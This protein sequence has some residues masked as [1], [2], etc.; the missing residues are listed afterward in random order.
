MTPVREL[1][2]RVLAGIP[3]AIARAITWA[4]TADPRFPELLSHL[5]PRTGR[6]RVIG[7]TGA[8]GAGKSTLTAALAKASRA[9]GRRIG[10]IAVDP[11][12]PFT[13]GAILGD[14]IRMQ[15]LYTD[16]GVMIRSMATRGHLGGLSRAT[17]DAVDVLDAA[18]FDDVLV[19]TVGVGQ[20]EV[21][22][23]RLAET[24]VVLLTPGMGDDIQAIK[25]GLMEVADVFVVNKADR[26][27]ADRTVQEVL[28]ML[29]M[30][31][32]GAWIPPVLKT[33]A[34]TGEGVPRLRAELEK[35][36]E[37]LSGPSGSSRRRERTVRR[38]ESIVQEKLLAELHGLSGS[39]ASIA[40]WAGRIEARS[41]DPFRAAGALL[42][43]LR[44]NG[45]PAAAKAGVRKISH[46]GLAVAS[47]DGG[48]S[49]WDL[50]GLAE[51]HREE[52]A[53]QKVAHLVPAGRRVEP[54]APRADR[55]REPHREVPR[56]EG[57]GAPPRL[58]RGR[59]RRR[60]AREAEGGGRE[61]RERDAVRRGPRLP[62]GVRP[63]GRDGGRPP[64]ALPAEAL[65]GRRRAA[66]PTS[67][68]G[69]RESRRR[70]RTGRRT[71]SSP[72]SSRPRGPPRP[73]ASCRPSRRVSSGRRRGT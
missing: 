37:F 49:F 65:K 24:C 4:E 6:A 48:G 15:E 36:R 25:A 10:I 17:A 20:D 33:V 14:R 18:G 69:P 67:P 44:Q 51:A 23:F 29:E 35:H 32:H 43:T 70:G 60:D 22:V 73:A 30:G 61:A 42:E 26:E 62:R 50:L 9:D 3:P 58:P 11:S 16:P 53:S 45:G 31:E 47:V 27:G 39:D 56:E 13:G 28:Q 5:W 46:L 54:R 2:E 21:E 64:R 59:R 41:E 72:S 71:E 40:A 34:R 52:V 7:L 38:I 68:G 1:A 55:A 66:R 19:E 63:P 57:P 8:P 12:S